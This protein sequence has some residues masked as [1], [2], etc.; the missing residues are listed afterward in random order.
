VVCFQKAEEARAFGKALR[1]RLSKY[2]LKIS[3][4][5]SGIIPFGRYPYLSAIKKGKRLA[6]FDFLGF[7]HY[8]TKTRRGYFKLGRKNQWLKEIRNMI[9]LKEW[10]EVLRAKLLGHYHYYG[11]SGNMPEMKAFYKHTRR[12]AFKWINR[13]SQKKSYNWIQFYNFLKYNP[14]PK[15]KIYH[16]TYTLS[17]R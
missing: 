2:G 6:T 12:L 16:L 5:K 1:E 11:L 10:W 7:T 3:E 9:K 15:S 4:V 14:L 17:L 13:R 8:C